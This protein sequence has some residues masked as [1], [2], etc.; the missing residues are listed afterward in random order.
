MYSG[1][2]LSSLRMMLLNM[3][4]MRGVNELVLSYS[5]VYYAYTSSSNWNSSEVLHNQQ[6]TGGVRWHARSE[7]TICCPYISLWGIGCTHVSFPDCFK[8]SKL[9]IFTYF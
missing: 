2:S 8:F 1:L 4:Q 5:A 7:L 6:L 3:T 9:Y